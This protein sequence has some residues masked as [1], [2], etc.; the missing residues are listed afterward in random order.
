M[1]ARSTAWGARMLMAGAL[2]IAWLT[3]LAP[4]SARAQDVALDANTCEYAIDGECD[5][6]GIGTGVCA[7]GTDS[8][9]CRRR[10]V[11]SADACHFANDGECDEP[12]IGTALCP[13]RTDTTDCRGR[14]SPA[15]SGRDDRVFVPSAER[16]WS[17]IGRLET[18]SGHCSGVLVGP[19]LVL[20]AA[21]CFFRAE[22]SNER[23]PV[24]VFVAGKDG[25][26]EVARSRVVREVLSERFDNREHAE[27]SGIDGEDWGFL[28]L[29]DPIGDIAGTM[30]I[31]G[32][33]AQGLTTR[34]AQ[35]LLSAVTQAGYSADNGSKLTAHEGCAVTELFDDGTFFHECDAIDGDSGSPIFTRDPDG[36]FTIIGI[37]SATY[38][39]SDEDER[40][41]AV[42]AEK[43]F[44][45]WRA[46]MKE[47][48]R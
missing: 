30:R 28:V 40:E 47:T 35:G 27:T 36:G 44:D 12:S 15:F 14:W 10:G 22:D 38:P 13:R 9:D 24:L 7:A 25:P 34:F 29:E 20:T 3:A 17:S 31:D 33:G 1:G 2:A 48:T 4:E 8:W 46:L 11:L 18:E 6:P 37:M 45:T 32:S 41:M 42:A 5:E 26:N 21:H 16:P 23:D 39:E 19:R 43:F